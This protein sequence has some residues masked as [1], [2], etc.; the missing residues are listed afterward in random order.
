MYWLWGVVSVLVVIGLMVLAKGIFAWTP[1]ARRPRV[2][3]A[4]G[5]P[6]GHVAV[7]VSLVVVAWLI[8]L[9]LGVV[10]LLALV[11]LLIAWQRV[12]SGAHTDTQVL[13]GLALGA[14]VPLLIAWGTVRR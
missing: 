6:S 4:D 12:A 10:A 8:G 11:A 14:T 13:A 3:P 5:F 9:P 2:A 1:W 7:A